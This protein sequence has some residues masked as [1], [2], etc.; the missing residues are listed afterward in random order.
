MRIHR[1]N[2]DNGEYATMN[3]KGKWVQ[4]MGKGEAKHEN[5]DRFGM[6]AG[7]GWGGR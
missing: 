4:K 6:E 7:E 5:H 1:T 2:E 3:Y